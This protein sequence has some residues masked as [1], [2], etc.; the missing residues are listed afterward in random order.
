MA[1][2][3]LAIV[4]DGLSAADGEPVS[5]ALPR[6]LQELSR[7]ALRAKI[8]V[9][10]T[11]EQDEPFALT[12]IE[13]GGH[14]SAIGSAPAGDAHAST[15]IGP[16]EW[17]SAMQIVV[18]QAIRTGELKV[19]TFAPAALERGDAAALFAETLDL[20]AGLVRAGSAE[21]VN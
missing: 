13:N 14:K 1:S 11:I 10:P 4:F 20:V 18:G 6:I 3:Q 15:Q 19:L 2:A 8:F 21:V 7:R 17:H 16:A 5:P 9:E 12:M